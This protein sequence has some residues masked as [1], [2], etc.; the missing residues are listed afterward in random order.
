MSE[1]MQY[2]FC[3]NCGSQMSNGICSNCGFTV[4]RVNIG[5]VSYP[6]EMGI[7]GNTVEHKAGDGNFPTQGAENGVKT[8]IYGNIYYP[9]EPPKN[10]GKSLTILIALIAIFMI[11]LFAVILQ[12]VANHFAGGIDYPTDGGSYLSITDSDYSGTLAEYF[13]EYREYLDYEDST[14]CEGTGYDFGDSPYYV[15]DDY[16]DTS[17]SYTPMAKSWSFSN[18]D[19]WFDDAGGTFP[20]DLYIFCDY[21]NFENTAF[22]ASELNAKLFGYSA[23]I[24]K[25][26]ESLDYELREGEVVYIQGTVYVTYMDEKVASILYSNSLY[27]VLNAFT[28]S[29]EYINYMT[30]L[31]SANIDMTTGKIIKLGDVY[32]TDSH[33]AEVMISECSIQNDGADITEY[34]SKEDILS[35]GKKEE[36]V[37]FYT[38]LGVEFGVNYPKSSGY[39]TFTSTDRNQ[40]KK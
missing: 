11:V 10:D 33:F 39:C 38:P 9:T 15:F 2:N 24:A 1:Q 12:T 37:W 5:A 21:V 22:D 8:D 18:E 7:A 34:F 14:V 17:V 20:R 3:P 27:I 26:Y 6:P 32:K 31:S 19:G 28:E 16:I 25:L 29:E 23:D 40:F 36:I 35:L 30:E 4:N 13:K